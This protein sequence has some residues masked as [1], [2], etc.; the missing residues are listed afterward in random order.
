M[1]AFWGEGNSKG[2]DIYMLPEWAAKTLAP[3]RFNLMK[4]GAASTL[5]TAYEA[6][7]KGNAEAKAKLV[8][9]EKQSRREELE[10][11]AANLLGDI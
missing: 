11:K 3:L 10:I 4:E 6:H 5:V 2:V 7:A 8:T 1:P 9:I